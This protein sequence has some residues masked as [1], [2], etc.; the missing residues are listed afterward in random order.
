MYG[1]KWREMAAPGEKLSPKQEQSIICLLTAP[2]ITEAARLAGIGER[3]MLRWLS[4]GPFQE[5]YRE[6]RRQVVQHAIARLQQV[7]GEAVET[8]R[9]VMQDGN[10][11]AS[12]KVSAARTVLEMAVKAVELEDLE[13]RI[14]D[15]EEHIAEAQEHVA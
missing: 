1:R 14:A 15:L 9:Q 11:P 4:L 10:A 13:A 8:L 12:A 7:T 2:N 5:A 3:T 6:A